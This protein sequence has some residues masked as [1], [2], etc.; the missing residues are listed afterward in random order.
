MGPQKKNKMTEFR[1]I[2]VSHSWDPVDSRY[3]MKQK[4]PYKDVSKP[5]DLKAG[6]V[7]LLNNGE[8]AFF[9]FLQVSEPFT[10]EEHPELFL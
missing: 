1:M 3:K 9:S 2:T 4:I 7:R 6:N 8:L 10:K 5:H